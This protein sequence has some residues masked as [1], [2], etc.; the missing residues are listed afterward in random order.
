MLRNMRD[1]EKQEVIRTIVLEGDGKMVPFR[2]VRYYYSMTGELL[3]VFD[4]L[5]LMTLKAGV[6]YKSKIEEKD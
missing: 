1:A 2:D 4:P 3:A 5:G 6:I